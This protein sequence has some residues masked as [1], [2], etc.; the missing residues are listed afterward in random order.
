MYWALLFFC[1]LTLLSAIA[2]QHDTRRP[3]T[4][5]IKAKYRVKD[6][7]FLRKVLPFK[8]RKYYPCL[9]LKI[10]PIFILG[11]ITIVVSLAYAI[12]PFIGN[13]LDIFFKSKFSLILSLVI[14]FSYVLYQVIM[15]TW[16]DFVD[17]KEMKFTREEKALLKETRR[18][19]REY[20]RRRNFTNR[21][22]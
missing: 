14:M 8:D 7:S 13:V 4:T 2:E 11:I 15:L 22:E 3:Q 10:V 20:K 9:Y 19:V 5:R 16:W 17:H 6:N 1:Y 12:N 21:S 18:K